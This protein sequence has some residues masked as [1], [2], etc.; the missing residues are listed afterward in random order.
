MNFLKSY[1]GAISEF[2]SSVVGE[3]EQEGIEEEQQSAVPNPQS[4]DPVQLGEKN[5]STESVPSG[6]ETTRSGL[7]DWVPKLQKPAGEPCFPVVCLF[8]IKI[9]NAVVY[10]M[11]RLASLGG[12]NIA[13]LKEPDSTSEK[14]A[15]VITSDVPTIDTPPSDVSGEVEDPS[16]SDKVAGNSQMEEA[17]FDWLNGLSARTGEVSANGRKSA[18]RNILA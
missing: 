15:S 1:V 7:L 10:Y 2:V 18:L 5:N 9:Q 8:K 3:S 6:K 12:E 4:N 11:N 16:T 14:P 13:D 17:L